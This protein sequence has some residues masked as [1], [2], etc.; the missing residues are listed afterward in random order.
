MRAFLCEPTRIFLNETPRLLIDAGEQPTSLPGFLRSG[1]ILSEPLERHPLAQQEEDTEF[2]S[3]SLW[4][5]LLEATT[6]TPLSDSPI[7]FNE[8]TASRASRPP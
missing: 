1:S 6:R 2:Q 8:N 4:I 5:Q 3:V 7:T